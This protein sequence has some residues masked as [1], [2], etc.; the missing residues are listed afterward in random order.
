MELNQAR[1]PDLRR[2]FEASTRKLGTTRIKP[3]P[4]GAPDPTAPL[5]AGTQKLEPRASNFEQSGVILDPHKPRRWQNRALRHRRELLS[6]PPVNGDSA[7]FPAGKPYRL[8]SAFQSPHCAGY[9][10]LAEAGATPAWGPPDV[11]QE[12]RLKPPVGSYFNAHQLRRPPHPQGDGSQIA[13]APPQ[14][15]IAL[16][17]MTS[18]A[19]IQKMVHA[20]SRFGLESPKRSKR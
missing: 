17:E 13:L 5:S 15:I 6:S 1:S 9:V 19:I 11:T 7:S 18:T 3:A 12:L 14:R 8:V 2:R 20:I 4:P 16:P 10:A